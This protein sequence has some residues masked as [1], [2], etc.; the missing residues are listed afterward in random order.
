MSCVSTCGYWLLSFTGDIIFL[1]LLLSSFVTTKALYSF[2]SKVL[3]VEHYVV[4][5]LKKLYTFF[6]HEWT[7]SVGASCQLFTCCELLLCA[8]CCVLYCVYGI[9]SSIIFW[10][11]LPPPLLV[12]LNKLVF[13]ADVLIYLLLLFFVYKKSYFPYF[14]YYFLFVVLF[15]VDQAF[16]FVIIIALCK[17]YWK[18]YTYPNTRCCWLMCIR[19]CSHSFIH[20]RN[21]ANNHSRIKFITKLCT[22]I[23]MKNKCWMSI[24]VVVGLFVYLF[25][26]INFTQQD[27]L[28]T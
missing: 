15:Q 2:H 28:F 6:R 24:Y 23:W 21:F 7:W 16:R 18:F 25:I 17:N 27:H 10:P 13:F 9:I 22:H 12:H 11:L 19:N 14:Y 3:V 26:W 5:A 20:S 4:A 8:L 1:F